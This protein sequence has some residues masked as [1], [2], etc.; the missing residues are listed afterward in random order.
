MGTKETPVGENKIHY[1]QPKKNLHSLGTFKPTFSNVDVI[2]NSEETPKIAHFSLQQLSG[3]RT[4]CCSE[5]GRS[6]FLCVWSPKHLWSFRKAA[7]N[8]QVVL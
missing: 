5:P 1:H 8:F 2:N 4:R 3:G 7:Q 6:L